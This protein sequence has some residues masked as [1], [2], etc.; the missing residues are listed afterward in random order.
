MEVL[1]ILK[2]VRAVRVIALLPMVCFVHRHSIL[3][4]SMQHVPLKMVL[5][6][7]RTTV[8]VGRKNVQHRLVCFVWARM[9]NVPKLLHVT[10]RMEVKI[11]TTVLVGHAIVQHRLVCFVWPIIASLLRLHIVCLVCLDRFPGLLILLNLSTELR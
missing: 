1:S 2:V 5:K 3:A 8:L 4:G 11:Q 10:K 6:K 7:T 9:T